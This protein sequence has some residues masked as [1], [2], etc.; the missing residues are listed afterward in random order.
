[1]HGELGVAAHTLAKPQG[2]AQAWRSLSPAHAL[3]V[4]MSNHPR[5]SPIVC[6]QPPILSLFSLPRSSS[7]P[8]C[9]LTGEHPWQRC[10][11]GVSSPSNRRRLSCPFPTPIAPSAL[12]AICGR[13]G[14]EGPDTQSPPVSISRV[15][16]S[17]FPFGS[18]TS[19]P[20]SLRRSCAPLSPIVA[21]RR[22][23]L[24]P[25]RQCRALRAAHRPRVAC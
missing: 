7:L 16:P 18:L 13:D 10:T 2:T 24:D 14:D 8:F 4:T 1:M 9:V 21:D 5:S 3:V 11:D 20:R 22:A 25:T 12:H 19:R 23:P 17:F 6:E 15:A